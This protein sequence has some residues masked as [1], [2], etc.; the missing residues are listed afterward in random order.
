MSSA[1]KFAAFDRVKKNGEGCLI[2]HNWPQNQA[3]LTLNNG[4]LLPTGDN[5]LEKFFGHYFVVCEPSTAQVHL[6]PKNQNAIR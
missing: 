2:S 1:S 3:S 4:L 6:A 5:F